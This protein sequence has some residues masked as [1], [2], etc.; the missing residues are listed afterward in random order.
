M[1][2]AVIQPGTFDIYALG[3]H[4]GALELAGCD[5]A[6]QENPAFRII[7][8]PPAY[9]QLII[10]LRDLQIIHRKPSHRQRNAQP[11]I[12]DL[13]DV[14]GRVAI[15]ILAHTVE[16]L[17]Q[18]IEAKKQRGAEKRRSGHV[19]WPPH[20]RAKHWPGPEASRCEL[21]WRSVAPLQGGA[22]GATSPP[23]A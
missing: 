5:A 8:L 16:H 15:G 1:Q 7:L 10:F 23:L 6:M 11:V 12:A 17:F 14:V 21:S 22:R 9:H 20:P 2:Q 3:Q 13:F 18:M 4:K 19:I